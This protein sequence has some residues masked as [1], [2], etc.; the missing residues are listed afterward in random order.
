VTGARVLLFGASGFI[1]RHVATALA[2]EPRVESLIHVGRGEPA[3]EHWVRHD[4]VAHDADKLEQL[5]RVV[6]PDAVVNCAGSLSGGAASL[7]EANTLVTA[8]LIDAVVAATPAARLVVLGSA[9]EYGV[10]P[11]GRPVAEDDPEEPVSVYGTCKSASSR[12]VRLA[13]VD[14]LLDAVVLRVFNPIGPGLPAATLL[15]TAAAQMRDALR[16]GADRIELGALGG[17]R[18]FVDVRDVAAAVSAAALADNVKEPVLNVGS[19]RAVSARE[20]VRR[21]AD[22]ARYGGQ[23]SEAASASA[24]SGKV[25]WIAADLSK[26][27][28]CLGWAPACSLHSSLKGIWDGW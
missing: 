22:V 25:D 12:L 13:V 7:V 10:V 15:G 19:G 24:R 8:R 5:L 3:N 21:L 27:T 16:R 1:G 11:H 23:I 14:A 6:R 26:I 2:R 20:A 17:Y 4:L 18:D 9:A 28:Q